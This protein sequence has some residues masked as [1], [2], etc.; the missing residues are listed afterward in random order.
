MTIPHRSD[1]VE[2]DAITL[3]PATDA[4]YDFM[5][6]L[7]HSAR[8]EEM[9]HFP[10]GD[11]QKVAFLDWQFQCQWTHYREHYPTCDWRIIER[12][13]EAVGRLLIDR[14]PDQ[15]RIVDIALLTAARG[16]G[17]GTMLMREVLEEGRRANKPVTIHV[18]VFN[19][20]QNLY[21][22]LG[23]AQVDSSGAY[24][25]MRWSPDQVNTAS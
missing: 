13:G 6:V 17:L 15:I 2:R 19:P 4:D 21:R 23:F 5:R 12:N 7:Y 20:A 16:S 9:Q 1:R 25:L 18:E 22:R 11:E 14:W 10:L 3:R 24:H 8:E